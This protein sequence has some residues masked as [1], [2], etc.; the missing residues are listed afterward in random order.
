MAFP[1]LCIFLAAVLVRKSCQWLPFYPKSALRLW[2]DSFGQYPEFH[3]DIFGEDFADD[4]KE[5]DATVIVTVAPFTLVLVE[6]D[7]VGISY[8]LWNLTFSP[9]L[10][11]YLM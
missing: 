5:R 10:A 1:A 11:K 3:Q 7:Y 2:V 6:S 9:A 8:V 4:V